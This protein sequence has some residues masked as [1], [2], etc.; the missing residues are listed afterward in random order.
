MALATGLM[1]ADPTESAASKLE[2]VLVSGDLA[3]L[4]PDQRVYYYHEVCESVG[5]NPLTKPF[6]YLSLNGKLVLYANRG[7]T[8]QLR[9]IRSIEVL[10]L[11][12]AREDDLAIVIAHGR[13]RTGRRDSALGAVSIKNLAGEA[14]AN[15]LMKAETKAKRRLTL[16]L[17]G[18]GLL[19]E[20]EVDTVPGAWRADVDVSTGE[21]TESAAPSQ[22][23][24]ERV[25]A[26]AATVT[27]EPE[28]ASEP[29][30]VTS[31]P[32][33]GSQLADVA[34]PDQ[35]QCESTAP[36]EGNARCRREAG[37]PGLH[38]AGSKESWE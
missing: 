26:K 33:E 8:D 7:C 12:R 14:L 23:L 4:T 21:I 31:V 36:Y 17:S 18:L 11:E 9:S 29:V 6:D 34:V 22:S 37:H 27:A 19:D 3:A 10:S 24:A 5:L 28:A 13:D 15:A 32:A 1:I 20:V 30:L 16:S 25:A 38:S 35:T 2:K